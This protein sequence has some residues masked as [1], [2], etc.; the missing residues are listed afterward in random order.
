M[1]PMQAMDGLSAIKLALLREK[2]PH[3]TTVAQREPI[4]ILGFDCRFPGGEDPDGFWKLLAESRC[5]AGHV[6]PDR[7]DA[8]ALY[9]GDAIAPGT[10]AAR[11][12]AFLSDIR[13][14]D[15]ALFHISGREAA[16]M[17]PQ[18]R[19]L[20][21]TT[22][23]ALERAAIAPDSLKGSRTGVFVGLASND[24]AA[25]MLSAND[26]TLVDAHFGSG[27]SGAFAAGRLAYVL[28]AVGPAMTL[29]AT[30]ASSLVA[31]H[32]ACSSL[33]SG[34]CDVAIVG[35]V[36][37]SLSPGERIYL[38]QAG[39]LSPSGRSR[40][41]AADADGFGG[42]E[43]CAVL[44]LTRLSRAIRERHA[45]VG[46][47]RGSAVA[48]GGASGGLTVPSA[49]A[50]E[51]VI[52]SALDSAGLPPAS[53]DYVETHGT[54][55][56]LGD[57]IE[58][59]ALSAVFAA[60]RPAEAPLPIGAVKANVGHAQAA[61]GLCGVAKVLLAMQHETIPAQPPITALSR[62]VAWEE[63][64]LA[65][66]TEQR[67]WRRADRPRRAGVSAFGLSGTNA[68]VVIEEAPGRPGPERGERPCHI[69]PLSARSPEALRSF[70]AAMGQAAG[71]LPDDAL[72]AFCHSAA[73]GRARHAT[74]A[75]VRAASPAE[76][77]ERLQQLAEGR[78]LAP[79]GLARPGNGLA[80]HGVA[81]MVSGQ[82]TAVPGAGEALYR[83]NR[84][85][86]AC[87]DRAAAAAAPF[88]DVPLTTVMFDTER[89]PALLAQT[90]YAQPALAALAWALGELWQSWGVPCAGLIGHSL[91]EYA[92]AALAGMISPEALMELTARRGELMARPAALGAM[93][94]IRAAPDRAAELIA[95]HPGLSIAV[96]N[97]PAS[98]V[99]A[100][101]KE[102][103]AKLRAELAGQRIPASLLP[104]DCGFHS[105]LMDPLLDEL[106]ALAAQAGFAAPDRPIVS[107]LS[108]TF[109]SATHAP[110]PAYWA[111]H[112]REPVRFHDGLRGLYE[113]GPRLFLELGPRPALSVLG[114]QSLGPDARFLPSLG[115]PE[116]DWETLL[117]SAAALWAE[118][119]DIDWT[120]VNA[121]LRSH[122]LPQ[123]PAPLVRKPHW[124]REPTSP[125]QPLEPALGRAEM[126]ST[127][128]EQRIRA[129]LLTDLAR[130]LDEPPEAISPD[131]SFVELGA[132]S[133]M[134]AEAGRALMQRYGTQIPLKSLFGE[135][136]SVARLAAHIAGLVSAP[137][138]N[139]PQAV[140]PTSVPS[141]SVD[142]ADGDVAA[143]MRQQL[144]TMTNLMQAQL[145]ALAR[146]KGEVPQASRVP[147]LAQP[148][149]AVPP[150]RTS[151]ASEIATGAAN[152]EDPRRSAHRQALADAYT[153]RTARSK[154]LADARRP[155]FADVRAAAGFRPSVKEMLYPISGDR[156][157]GSRIWDVDGN[158]YI[159]I[160]MDFGVNLF[161]HASPL[162]REAMQAQLDRGLAL[163]PRSPLAGE[164]A[165][166]LCD[167]TGMDRV[168]FNQSGTES[169]MTAVRLARLQRGRSRIAVF[170]NSYHGHFDGF[171]GDRVDAAGRSEVMPVAGGILPAFVNDLLVLDYGS[172]AALDAIRAEADHLAAVV[173]EP[174]QSRALHLQPREFLHRL[175]DLTARHGIVLIFDE[176]ITGLRVHPGGA[177]AWFGVEADLATYGKTLGGGVPMAALAAR[178]RLLDGIDGGVWKYGDASAPVQETTFFAG[179]FNNHPLG[180]A[181]ARAVL[182]EMKRQG[183]GLQEAL[184]ARTADMATRL[185][186]ALAA[187]DVPL[188]VL[189]YGSVFRFAHKGNL[190]LLYYH[191]LHRGLFVWEGRNCFL[192]TA[193]TD[194]DIDAIVERTLDGVAALQEGGFLAGRP[195]RAG[196]AFAP[197]PSRP[198]DT[199]TDERLPLTQTQRQIL[200]AT[201]RAAEGTAPYI[202]TVAVD[203]DGP[204]DLKA[205]ERALLDLAWRHE[206]LRTTIDEAE[207]CQRVAPSPV[208]ALRVAEA[209]TDGDAETW[210]TTFAGAPF[211]A[212]KDSPLR[213]GLFRLAAE[214]HLL[215]LVTHHALID[216]WSLRL[217]MEELSRHY[218]HHASGAPLPPPTTGQPRDHLARLQDLGAA[219]RAF[220]HLAFWEQMLAE[221]PPPLPLHA[222]GPRPLNSN[223]PAGR[224]RLPLAAATC[225]A[226]E[227]L[228]RRNEVSLF[229]AA[230]GVTLAY[231]HRLYDRDDLLLGVPAHGRRPE[232]SHIV[233]QAAQLMPVRS[234][235]A[236]DQTLDGFIRELGARF[237]DQAERQSELELAA[238]VAPVLERPSGGLNVTFNLDRISLPST[239]GGL[240]A[241]LRDAPV[242]GAKFDLCLNLT[243]ADGQWHLDLDYDADAFSAA[244]IRRMGGRWIAWAEHAGSASDAPIFGRNILDAADL[245]L[246]AGSNATD[247]VFSEEAM[248][249]QLIAARAAG[250]PAATAV[251]FEGEDLTYGELHSAARGLAGRMIEA[252]VEPGAIVA[253]TMPRSRELV[254]ALLGILYA[255]AA[256]LPIDP[257]DP[258]ERIADLLEDAKPHLL[259]VNEATAESLPT[260]PVPVLCV[261]ADAC[262]ADAEAPEPIPARAG[263]AAYV[264]FTSGSTGRPKAVV[265]EHGGLQ[266]R[267]LWM[268]ER[269]P[270]GPHSVVLQK[271]PY[272]FDV[273]VWEFLW[274]LMTGAC[275]VLA[276]PGGHRDPAYLAGLIR[277]EGVTAI[278]FVPSMLDVFLDHPEA[279]DCSSLTHVFCSGE[280]LSAGLRDRFFKGGPKAE[281]HNLYGPTEASIDVT[282]WVCSVEDRGPVPIGRPIANTRIEILDARRQPVAPGVE[283]DLYIGGCQLARG[284]LNRP[285]L[286]AERFIPH[287]TRLSERLY[288]SGDRARYRQ[289]GA[290]EYLGRGDGQVKL[291]GI[292][293]ELGEIEARLCAHPSVREAA[294]TVDGP[295]V[296]RHLVAWVVPQAGRAEA[297]DLAF[298]RMEDGLYRTVLPGGRALLCTS[299]QEVR[300]MVEETRGEGFAPAA[301]GLPED[302]VVIDAG[303]NIGVF[304]L[305]ILDHAP[306]ANIL[307]CEVIPQVAEVLERNASSVQEKIRVEKVALGAEAGEAEFT[308]YPGISI[309]SGRH[310]D[311]DADRAP[312]LSYLG[313]DGA[314]TPELLD[315]ILKTR[316][317]PVRMQCPVITVSDLVRR[318]GLQRVDLLKV[319]VEG[320]EEAV[321]AGIAPEHW[322][323]IDRV[324]VE[325]DDRDGARE[326]IEVLLREQGFEVL[327][328][329][330][331]WAGKTRMFLLTA[332]RGDLPPPAAA[333]SAAPADFATLAGELRAYLTRHLPAPYIPSRFLRLEA[334]PLGAHGK[335]DR[336]RLRATEPAPAQAEGTPPRSAVEAELL[337]YWQ[338]TLNLPVT[339][340][341]QDFFAI[342][343]QSLM[344]ASLLGW[345]QDQWRT[346]IDL[347]SF[348]S[349]PTIAVLAALIER[350]TAAQAPIP[351]RPRRAGR[352]TRPSELTS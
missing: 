42:G 251:R 233:M 64:G 7:W 200:L 253:V 277:Q 249:P 231:F 168:L 154:E 243:I 247:R 212:T 282:H 72:A 234:R 325:A 127:S 91:G 207:G 196:Q 86:R 146:L 204:L 140:P 116:G 100:G 296:N 344:A 126:D 219:A 206:A 103:V 264:L 201:A 47:V 335:L 155:R 56:E 55:T 101:P 301:L 43:G 232:E 237:A 149:S 228:A 229:T 74:R 104:V 171:L 275:M 187:N 50:Q 319:D 324:L 300:F 35:G 39:A 272:T 192:S 223:R 12:G 76:M 161:G 194:A 62:H 40:P 3:D 349:E 49:S 37:L 222:D 129:E 153:R 45:I 230:F 217:L 318:H 60:D 266:N 4:A 169:V 185:N 58:L 286:T 271:T 263:D 313:E 259:L 333:G 326:R 315:E 323:L 242:F 186:T 138:T 22:W 133:I 351:V 34:E 261:A 350:N 30:C 338:Q 125:V 32:Q 21:E 141:P 218:A 305:S 93:L 297:A 226:I 328:E 267:L 160:S 289:D 203:L 290:I 77:A 215:V 53:I 90:R 281:L 134:L 24:Y 107:G 216:G 287:P 38:S 123:P 29:D 312:L 308:W 114:E 136:G 245:A 148:R 177:Q 11:E 291:R 268:Q 181:A 79:H 182:G 31:L 75:A 339:G 6:P 128:T 10:I 18:Q 342:G 147:V 172:D 299:P 183:P 20:L 310:A 184:N 238:L 121:D 235:P 89:G 36:H 19:L 70:A 225:R 334:M 94:S 193:H 157:E 265:N 346:R 113:N 48:H 279:K 244:G 285:D 210:L 165:E 256:W 278:H 311:V 341:D 159:D 260:L 97:T 106:A 322:P 28:G 144:E 105:A 199:Q 69:Y 246:I 340:T 329:Q 25:R 92:A 294:V 8:A 180:L 2:L 122:R 88:L 295:E 280:A 209:G 59:R 202:D 252:G 139:A 327:A 198:V 332:W 255:G 82:G 71:A 162:I 83:T 176:M 221:P 345:A 227:E 143:L 164:V 178:G 84:F 67:P 208:V 250:C 170:R 109:H 46:L 306:R 293:I 191:L 241:R 119:V 270:L 239:I 57:P 15:A 13:G 257:E 66:V 26:P 189:H 174:V 236:P 124:F 173:V 130:I 41:F 211:D 33:R 73:V 131:R 68:H 316:L 292:R 95:A 85:F 54:G 61:A 115:G 132:D 145:A 118:G 284:Y 317:S 307:A 5:A 288:W 254:V 156:A 320:D 240:V 142:A 80:T 51:Q 303:A 262:A 258:H 16:S 158:E 248:V 117:D 347:R 330:A 343:G 87:I 14:F 273:S 81:F 214:R 102:A 314:G 304:A 1:K 197:V 274:P 99:V 150:A 336:R 65:L 96:L 298:E 352:S 205:F 331:R 137:D 179:T 188:S 276:R 309:L 23:Q 213:V 135:L 152:A 110:E 63:I 195:V 224:V 111:R 220:E 269:F 120:A 166:L 27:N 190:D 98:T 167:L 302:A 163:G 112:A 151:A 52:R 108:G 337:R 283:G 348:L 44:V 17:D 9:R 78:G 175:R 321:L